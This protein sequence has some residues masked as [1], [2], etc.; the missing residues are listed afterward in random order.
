MTGVSIFT[1]TPETGRSPRPLEKGGI[2]SWRAVLPLDAHELRGGLCLA[3]L[4]PEVRVQE[5]WQ[6]FLFALEAREQDSIGA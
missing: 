2:E 3:V 5:W 4:K 6:W 1:V